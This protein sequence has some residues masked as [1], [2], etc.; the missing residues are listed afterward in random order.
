MVC[1]AAFVGVFGDG[2]IIQRFDGGCGLAQGRA[3]SGE[4]VP[5]DQVARGGLHGD[6]IQR[7]ADLP[8][9][10]VVMGDRGTAGDKAKEIAAFT[11]AETRVEITLHAG[12]GGD[13]N[14]LRAQVGVDGPGKAERVPI[15]RKIAMGD[16]ACG[17]HAGVGAAC[18]LDDMRAGLQAGK[19]GLDG[20][21]H[22]GLAAGLAL[23]AVERATVVVDFQGI[24]R[25]ATGLAQGGVCCNAGH[26]SNGIWRGKVSA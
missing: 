12:D 18:A 9:K 26:W 14:G 17:M 3:E 24:A 21:L 8:D 20:S 6:G 15:A 25:H 5:A 11:G 10:P 2:D 23:P 7:M 4:V 1:G 19:G 16:L 22:G 13:G